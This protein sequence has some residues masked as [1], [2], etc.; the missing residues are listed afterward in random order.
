M[1]AISDEKKRTHD[2]VA[3]DIKHK[4]FNDSLKIETGFAQERAEY[5]E[6]IATIQN[7]VYLSVIGFIILI[8]SL[9]F[10]VNSNRRKKRLNLIL[11]DKNVLI[12]E[13]KSIVDERNKAISDSINYAKRLQT[14]I[15]PTAA[16]VNE[17]LPES[18]LLFKPKDVVS[19]DFH[20]FES[21]EDT[22]F[23]AAADCT[24]HGVPGA[25]VSVV[26]SN[27]LN[28][29]VNEFNLRSTDKIL[30]KTRELVIET[31][32]KSEKNVDDGMD[33]ALCS[34]NKKTKKII[35]SG[36][37][38]PLWI[39]RKNEF[40][41]SNDTGNI[42]KGEKVSLIEF[43]G[44]KQPIGLYENLNDF[45]RVEVDVNKGD[46]IYLFTDGFADQF[47]GEA[48][49]KFKYKPF[50]QELLKIQALELSAQKEHLESLFDKW[51]GDLEQVDDVC[52]IGF[53][54]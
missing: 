23:I 38:N 15:L 42:L 37:N 47:G 6:E 14:A 40:I 50:K 45:S 13:Q 30:N 36:A 54:L 44:D 20:W 52:V 19:G 34:I 53:R 35:F 39:V 10:V 41:S 29:A 51:K 31:F 26:C 33:I 46:M 2:L 1:K 18:F 8:A 27:A 3:Q 43:K 21:K 7:R 49:K 12:Q 28:R 11:S 48:G 17:F 9:F 22:F 25:M 5:H 16:L 32:A 4:Y 24:G